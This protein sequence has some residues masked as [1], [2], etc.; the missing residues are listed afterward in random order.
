MREEVAGDLRRGHVRMRPAEK[1][2][3]REKE[4]TWGGQMIVNKAPTATL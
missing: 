4:N 3:E 1:E 2:K